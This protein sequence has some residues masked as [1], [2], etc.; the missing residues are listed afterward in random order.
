MTGSHNSVPSSDQVP[1]LRNAVVPDADTDA[2]ADAVSWQ[3]GAT[4]GVPAR[5][6]D[7]LG[8]SAPII[9]P[10]C[11]SRCSS[12]VGSPISSSIRVAHVRVRAS[13]NCVVVATVYSD[14]NAAR[15]PVVQQIRDRDERARG[16][17]ERRRRAAGGI[18]LVHRVDRQK[19]DAGDRVDPLAAHALEHGVHHAVGASVAIVIGVLEQVA[20]L[21]DERVVDAPAVD[22]D[23][24]EP[25]CRRGRRARAASRCQRWRMSHCREPF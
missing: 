6:A 2:T 23:A 22:A 18:E 3:A 1:E 9:V 14:V 25:A 12:R 20:A 10:G 16:V 8:C 11:T 13:M 17:D 24:V 15:Q 5:L 19:L 21:A 4:T 7:T